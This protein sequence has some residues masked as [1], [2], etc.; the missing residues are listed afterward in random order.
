MPR[1]EQ[2]ATTRSASGS[3]VHSPRTQRLTVWRETPV[4]RDTSDAVQA[5]VERAS[6]RAL[7]MKAA[8]AIFRPGEVSGTG[9]R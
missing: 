3:L 5:R 2:N 9:A 7:R 4:R 8:K 1:P 6:S